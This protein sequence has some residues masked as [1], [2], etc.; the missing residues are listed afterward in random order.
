MNIGVRQVE[1]DDAESLQRNC[2]S[3]TTIEQTRANV[4]AALTKATSGEG[5]SL[6][7][8]RRDEVVGNVTVTRNAHLLQ[9]HRAHLGGLLSTRRSKAKAWHERLRLLQHIGLPSASAPSWNSTAVAE[10]TPRMRTADSAFVSRVGWLVA[11]L[12]T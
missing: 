9:R 12:R 2:F 6:V 8:V 7:A 5:T 4:E 11:R 3:L 1:L 10:H